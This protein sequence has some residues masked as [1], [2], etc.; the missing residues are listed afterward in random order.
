MATGGQ[1]FIT[2]KETYIAAVLGGVTGSILVQNQSEEYPCRYCVAPTANGV[3][4]TEVA[5]YMTLAY[6]S[7]G[8]RITISGSE[9]LYIWAF[10]G[11]CEV[12]WTP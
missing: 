7:E 2:N 1:S 10:T 5:N 6:Q 11:K 4:D 9:T 3:P 12:S 8:S